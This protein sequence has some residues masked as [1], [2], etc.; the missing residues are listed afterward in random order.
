[1]L[2]KDSQIQLVD[3]IRD[4]IGD[5]DNQYIRSTKYYDDFLQFITMHYIDEKDYPHHIAQN[6]IY[7]EFRINHKTKQVTVTQSGHIWLTSEDQ[8]KSYLAMTS[9][10]HLMKHD[11]EK[12]FRT[13]HYKDIDSLAKKIADF[14]FSVG[15]VVRMRTTGYPYTHMAI[16]IY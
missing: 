10:K 11:N 3:K 2:Y 12:W 16:N 7:I 1:M 15:N 9:I 6:S 13:Q 14:Y 5:F 4:I 8:K